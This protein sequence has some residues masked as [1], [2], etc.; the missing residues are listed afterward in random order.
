MYPDDG[1][2]DVVEDV[3]REWR[4]ARSRAPSPPAWRRATCTSTR[5][6]ALPRTRSS[7]YTLL[8][9]LARVSE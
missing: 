7:R 8:A 3:R 4:A 5:A 2:H 1:Y 6:S 9:R